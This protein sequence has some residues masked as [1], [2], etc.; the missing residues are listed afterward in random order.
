MEVPELLNE[1]MELKLQAALVIPAKYIYQN[2]VNENVIILNKNTINS[3]YIEP[4]Y[5]YILHIDTVEQ[6][7]FPISQLRLDFIIKMIEMELP[8]CKILLSDSVKL[9]EV[10]DQYGIKLSKAQERMF[11]TLIDYYPSFF[12]F[13]DRAEKLV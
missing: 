13:W 7:E 12:K 10:R 9:K 2:K 8:E 3:N 5:D 11:P 6:N 1:R 4:G